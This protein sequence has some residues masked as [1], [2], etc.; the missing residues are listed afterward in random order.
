MLPLGTG[1][2]IALANAQG[3]PLEF[4]QEFIYRK[5]SK[6]WF[7]RTV[8]SL[9]EILNGIP[10]IVRDMVAYIIVVLPMGRFSA[11]AGGFTLGIHMIPLI[12]GLQRK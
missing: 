10:S 12:H 6:S 3:Y 2:L 1:I 11:L 8:R 4:C 5:N 9:A 7:A